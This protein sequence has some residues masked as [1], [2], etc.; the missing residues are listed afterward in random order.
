[1]PAVG[2]IK[3]GAAR[4]HEPINVLGIA[5]GIETALACRELFGVPT[6][7]AISAGGMEAFVVPEGV[8]RLIIYAD[9]DANMVGQSAAYALAKRCS[10]AGMPVEVEIPPERGTDWLDRL[11]SLATTTVAEGRPPASP[12][13]AKARP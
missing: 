7:A 2:T 9:H 12:Q 8:E 11:A 1:M 5:E 6:W 4:L 3:G 13:N 10:L